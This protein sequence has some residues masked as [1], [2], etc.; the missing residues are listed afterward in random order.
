M[1]LHDE[2]DHPSTY[3]TKQW[4]WLHDHGCLWCYPSIYVEMDVKYCISRIATMQDLSFSGKGYTVFGGVI[5]TR[6]DRSDI[7]DISDLRGKRFM[8]V[9]ETSLGGWRAAW[10]EIKRHGID[11][12]KDFASL[13]FINNHVDVVYAVRNGKVDAATV[14]T[15]TLERMA[16]RQEIDIREFK[17][18]PYKG[19]KGPEYRDFPFLLSTPLYPEWPI[20]KLIHTPNAVAK[21]VAS[22]LLDMP[23]DSPAA[24]AANIEG[25]TIPL[26][27]EP[28]DDL[29]RY[30]RVGPYEDYGQVTWGDILREH[31]KMITA[32]AAFTLCMF[33]FSVYIS[34]L[35]VLLNTSRRHLTHELAHRKKTE[36]ELTA[37]KEAA[38][39]SAKAKSAFL[40]NMSH[41]IRTPMN[42]ILGFLE[43]VMD[44]HNLPETYRQY[45]SIAR[46]SAQAL[47]GLLN[48]ILDVSKMESGKMTLELKPFDLMELIQGV[49]QMFDINIRE[50]GLYFTYN[51]DPALTGN[52][53]G[54]PLRLRQIIINLIGNA[55]KFTEKGH[56]SIGVQTYAEEDIIHFDISDTG[57][58]IPPEAIERI[59]A[60][61]TQAD[62]SMTR[63]FGGTGLGTTISRQLVEMMGGRIW[64]E[65][66][67]GKGSTF[68]FTVNMKRTD[69]KSKSALKAMD[70][71]GDNLKPSRVFRIL[72]AEDIEDNVILLKTRLQHQGHTVIVARN[73]IE[74]IEC[75][76]KG[77]VDII[78]MDIQM[79]EMDG[80]EA[81]QRIRGMEDAS[82]GH[83][84]IIA[85]TASVLNQE[86]EDYL[87]R[88]FDAVIGKPIDF[89]RLFDTIEGAVPDQERP[90]AL[91]NQERPGAVSKGIGRSEGHI[92]T[93]PSVD[94]AGEPLPNELPLLEGID[95]EKGLYTW[96]DPMVYVDALLDFSSRYGNAAHRISS[97]IEDNDIETA[98][99]TAHSITGLSGNLSMTD[100]YGVSGEVE[101]A[102]KQRD[103]EQARALLDRLGGAIS[104]V[105]ASIGSLKK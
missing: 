39:V 29:L 24:K 28:V 80:I 61:F 84:P 95:V 60:P 78:L 19:K 100:V 49:Y 14:R 97:L 91:K 16:A 105:V 69:A 83:I 57:I 86:R 37:A 3:K 54:D 81:L 46:N 88:G 98:H 22:A 63:R 58:G 38:E 47:L 17:V 41:D 5:F 75:L 68:H 11:P 52:F 35:N 1:I 36:I 64:V 72:V 96:R 59:F 48:D 33:F 65:S 51:V 70:A 82:G 99:R 4:R 42:S 87:R 2:D 93:T 18:I 101:R 73:G 9:N 104:T 23:K 44:G 32:I 15:D 12:E 77:Q 76:R 45:L 56:I 7:N 13:Y 43:L 85:L 50:K 89:G 71:T 30:L 92:V 90:G 62:V 10:G 20:A 40:A 94:R 8:G 26:N 31:W 74:A 27:Y 79:P 6:A 67:S 66:E 21:M 55:V 53:I 102:L 103:I 34:R 25:W